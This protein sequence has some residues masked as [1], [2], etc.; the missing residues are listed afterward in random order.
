MSKILR[1]EYVALKLAA[2]CLLLIFMAMNPLLAD[3][4]KWITIGMLHNWFSSAGCEQEVGRT[5]LTAD[6]QDGF[7]WPALYEYEDMQAAKA[8]WIGARNYNDPVAQKTFD[9]KVV[10]CG[11]RVLDETSEFMPQEFKLV[12]KF[13]HPTV[14]VDGALASLTVYRD[15]VD[16]IDENLAADRML[17]NVVNTSLGVTLTR[18]IYA[19]SQAYCDDFFIYDFVFKNT[20]IYN[21]AGDRHTQTLQD[22]IFFFQYRWAPSK[23]LG[24]Y[25]YY[26]APQQ[27]T[28][29]HATMNQALHPAYGDQIRATYA[30]QGLHS[31]YEGD[32]IGGPNLGGGTLKADGFLGGPQFPGVVAIHVDKSASDRTDDSNQPANLPYF[33]SDDGITQ[34]NEQFNAGRMTQEYLVMASGI[35]EVTHADAVGDGNADEL[36]LAGGGGVS[37]GMGYG[38]YTLAPGDSIHIVMAETVGGISW[39]K[40]K[41]VGRQWYDQVTP[42][43]LP[44][45]STTTDRDEFKDTWVFTGVDTLMRN[46]G[47]AK[48]IWENGLVVDPPPPPPGTFSVTSGGDRITL[49]WTN[50]PESYDNFAGYRVYRSLDKPDTS[51]EMIYECGQG[52]SNSVVNRYED[53]TA[54]RGFDYYYYVT[55]YDDGTVSTTEPG[56]SLE[57]SLFWP[58]TTE[59]AYLRRMPGN[60]LADIRIVPNPYNINAKDYQFGTANKDRLMF[61]NLPPECIIRIFTERGDLVETIN[62]NDG[63]GDE[64]WRSITSSRQVVVSGLYIVHFETPEGESIV[65]KLIVIR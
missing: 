22:V 16:E 6:Q 51:F 13:N 35:P 8:L 28:W 11:P 9:H 12:G 10:H 2:V 61:Y 33:W 1:K 29:G 42:Y 40:R 17:Y 26:Y 65:K 21:Q 5:H 4:S 48:Q 41:S 56:F 7:Q 25:G 45:G 18:R 57:S 27:V 3:E 46:F 54:R 53:K 34:P 55:S 36:P 24:A 32:N 37:Q 38:P 23:H 39:E 52:T 14:V 20:G 59:P 15:V 62:H 64:E 44:D 43:V 63:S 50:E 31:K 47:I 60:K 30:W 49:E 58:R 19:Y